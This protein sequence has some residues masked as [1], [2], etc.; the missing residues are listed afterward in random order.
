MNAWAR[1]AVWWPEDVFESLDTYS[2]VLIAW[3]MVGASLCGW[4]LLDPRWEDQPVDARRVSGILTAA[5]GIITALVVVFAPLY[6]QTTTTDA[7]SSPG[8]SGGGRE[9]VTS[10]SLWDQGLP[11]EFAV[12]LAVFTGVMIVIGRCAVPDG[13][14]HSREALILLWVAACALLASVAV[15]I[16]SVG[17][18]L[19]P[20]A[21][22]AVVTAIH[23][24]RAR[25][26]A[27]SE[28]DAD[29]EFQHSGI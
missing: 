3:I 11:P 25:S 13:R 16:L 20:V 9:T 14:E 26:R 4:L 6:T 5:F 15:T 23:A 8:E 29:Q 1:I 19:L 7:P 10:V 17:V 27:E 22:L 28:S 18:F 24:T 2:L 21:A 12:M